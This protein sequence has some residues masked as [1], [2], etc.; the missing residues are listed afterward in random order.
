MPSTIVCFRDF[1]VSSVIN[2]GGCIPTE[3]F[4]F[5]TADDA[6]K[7]CVVE[8]FFYFYLLWLSVQPQQMLHYAAR[9]RWFWTNFTFALASGQPPT[10]KTWKSRRIW[11]WSGKSQG[12]GE[13]SEK[14]CFACGVL[15]QLWW[16]QNK[17]SLTACVLLSADDM[18]VM[19]CQRTKQKLILSIHVIVIMFYLIHL[20]T[21]ADMS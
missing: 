16:S 5:S 18:S 3:V 8:I 12:K 9:L 14:M 4:I 21:V 11:Q 6:C 2:A 15:P 1:K 17:H 19:D 20:Y 10:W 13:K 7:Y